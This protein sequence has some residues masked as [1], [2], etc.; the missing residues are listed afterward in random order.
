MYKYMCSI[1]ANNKNN[2]VGSIKIML[3]SMFSG[4]TTE[5]IREC[6]RWNSIGKNVLCINYDQDTRYGDDD[7]VY[8]HTK[9]HFRCKKA[10]LLSDVSL[11]DIINAD[12]ILINE[13]QFFSDLIEYCV[14]WCETYNKNILVS[15]LDGD[16][17]RNPFGKILDLIPYADSVIKLPALCHLCKNGTEAYFTCRLSG[18]KEQIVIG[19]DN[20][21]ALCRSHY[22][23]IT[24]A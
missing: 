4:K 1:S 22:I 8:S 18:E 19:S 17:Q 16:F 10:N 2:D 23:S 5:I 6:N 12:I 13:G 7:K 20:Y 21:V 24:S 15:G 3:G 11:D 9:E 14:K